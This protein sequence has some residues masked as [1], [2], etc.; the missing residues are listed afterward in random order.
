MLR[1]LCCLFDPVLL[2]NRPPEPQRRA[3]AAHV[4]LRPFGDLTV[5]RD[6]DP[7]QLL[8][9]LPVDAP[10]LAEII[11][12]TG[13]KHWSTALRSRWLFVDRDLWLRYGGRGSGFIVLVRSH[14]VTAPDR[15]AVYTTRHAKRLPESA[16]LI[17]SS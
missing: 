4:G 13:I 2:I 12:Q 6:A 14:F 1:Q 10:D 8:N 5:V 9:E 7:E 17:V 15:L 16:G 3:N 11:G